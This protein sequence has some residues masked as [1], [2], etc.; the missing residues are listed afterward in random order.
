M[1]NEKNKKGSVFGLFKSPY[2]KSLIKKYAGSY[3][4]GILILV[5]ID[6]L[7]TDQPLI[8]TEAINAITEGTFTGDIVRETITR[9]VIIAIAVFLGRIGWRWFIFGSARKIERDM[10][11]DLYTHL[12][13]MDQEFFHE[14]KAGEIM[15][16]M[17][18]DIETVR[19]AFA[20]TVMMGLDTITIGITTIYKM[21]T[22]ID[23]RL[24]LLC[25]I[26]MIMVILV[27]TFI[28][29]EMHKRYLARQKA[30][31]ALS[32]FVQEKL[33]GMK[34]IK[35]F[36]QEERE[37]R[38]FDKVNMETRKKNIREAKTQ[39]FM[40]PF[41][42]MIAG[43]SMAMAVGYGGYIALIGRIDIGQFSGFIM[44][45]NMLIWPM[46]AIGRIINLMTRGSASMKRLEAILNAEPGI[47]DCPEAKHVE[48][49]PDGRI[50]A[51]GL[52]FA[53][54]GE[55]GNVLKDVNFTVE[56]G[57]TLGIVGRTGSGKTTLVNLMMRVFDP[58]RDMLYIGGREIHEIPLKDLRSAIGYVPQDNFLFSDT[59]SANIAFGDHSKTQYDIEKA[60]AVACVHDNIIDFTDGYETLIG[61]RG[62]SLSGGQKQRISIAR[63]LILDPEILILD[64][65]VSAVDTDT[66]EQILRHLKETRSGKTNII[67]AHRISTLQNA[68]KIIVIDGNT[69]AECGTHEELLAINGI[70]ADMYN[71]QLLEK[72]KKEEYAL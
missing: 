41:M 64:D 14:H 44:Y 40:W 1:E 54:N 8:V 26:P 71:R 3:L 19:M 20:V 45:L 28:G 53:Y 27:S 21:I 60:A 12:Q 9:L 7:Q 13:T 62:V 42:R 49:S 22:K 52:T 38:E 29:R 15:A 57:Q 72:M 69:V 39:A 59:I 61:E 31:D 70:Y 65:S 34:V 5:V 4:I 18:S 46:A 56:K 24:S 58:P 10:R 47:K 51:K 17:S 6:Y 35:A 32:D 2:A 67:I 23:L 37:W 30:F 16:Y 33:N 43:L 48:G 25:F 63:A 36:V 55:D 66:E 68:D 50:E 11:N